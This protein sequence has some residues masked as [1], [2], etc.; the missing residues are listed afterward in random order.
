MTYLLRCIN[1]KEH[2]T[3]STRE[4]HRNEGPF[5]RASTRRRGVP[6][7][8]E[9]KVGMVGKGARSKIVQGSGGRVL[10]RAKKKLARQNENVSDC[11]RHRRRRS[12]DTSAVVD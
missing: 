3:K 7:E 12:S 4:N 8:K 2:C 10:A 9:K 6:K 11:R 5:R 1:K